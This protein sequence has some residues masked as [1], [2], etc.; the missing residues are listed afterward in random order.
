MKN[1]LLSLRWVFGLGDFLSG[2]NFVAVF[3]KPDSPFAPAS[4]IGVLVL[5]LSI[6]IARFASL[7]GETTQAF[8]PAVL[9]GCVGVFVIVVLL[10]RLV[11][12]AVG[13]SSVRANF[14]IDVIYA[15]IL[16]SLLLFMHNLVSGLSVV[17]FLERL[18]T[19]LTAIIDIIPGAINFL[20][21]WP[22]SGGISVSR[23]EAVQQLEVTLFNLAFAAIYALL[24]AF[25][26]LV[27]SDLAI[28]RYRQSNSEGY[29][30]DQS[31]IYRVLYSNMLLSTV[32]TTVF[33][34]LFVT[35]E[36]NRAVSYKIDLSSLVA[37]LGLKF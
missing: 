31:A 22:P 21:Q 29:R 8:P 34:F 15:H 27:R 20:I 37:G 14:V 11:P 17:P 3:S 2:A 13:D 10:T 32:V 25:I 30:T 36:T 6:T 28:R 1:D 5:A 4:L 24:A 9:I 19:D 18:D 33:V 23:L 12:L 7:R 35:D 26:L 16:L